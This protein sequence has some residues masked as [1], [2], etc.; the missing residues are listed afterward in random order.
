MDVTTCS[1]L[2]FRKLT[3]AGSARNKERKWLKN[4]IRNRPLE[5]PFRPKGEKQ[6][7]RTLRGSVLELTF[8]EHRIFDGILAPF[9]LHLGRLGSQ[10]GTQMDPKSII[11]GCHFLIKFWNGFSKDLGSILAPILEVFRFP[12]LIKKRMR[13]F[14]EKWQFV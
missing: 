10:N 7:T 1:T 9:W 13:E 14:S 4:D 6:I 11:L 2:L 3:Q 12:T 5:R 8:F